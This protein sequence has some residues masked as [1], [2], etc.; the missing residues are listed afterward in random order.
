[1]SKVESCGIYLSR[2]ECLVHYYQLK[3]SDGAPRRVWASSDAVILARHVC[4]ETAWRQGT[5]TGITRA[6]RN[7]KPSGGL[8]DSIIL[9]SRPFALARLLTLLTLLA[10]PT[11]PTPPFRSRNVSTRMPPVASRHIDPLCC[12]RADRDQRIRSDRSSRTYR[13]RS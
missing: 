13:R 1:M 3:V 2:S 5:T 6:D 8:L 7:H 9:Y 11:L 10:L 4:S 12:C